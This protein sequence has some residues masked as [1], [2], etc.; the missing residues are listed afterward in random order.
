M[1]SKQH[2]QEYLEKEYGL[3]MNRGQIEREMKMGNGKFPVEKLTVYDVDPSG[4][5][6]RYATASL[7]AY[8]WATQK[9]A[10]MC[11]GVRKK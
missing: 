6:K 9:P 1:T 8:L 10:I 3:W 7:A 2:I 11:L 4:K 5:R